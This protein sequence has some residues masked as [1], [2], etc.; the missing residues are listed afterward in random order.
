MAFRTYRDVGD[1]TPFSSNATAP[2]SEW[3]AQP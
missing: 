1:K 2:K 3:R